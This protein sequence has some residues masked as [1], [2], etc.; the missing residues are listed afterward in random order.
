M[1]LDGKPFDDVTYEDILALI[2]DVSENRRLDYKQA[3]PNDSEKSV[4]DFLADVCALANS[5]G[6]Y[7]VFGV[8]EE[9]D[10]DNK[11]NGI[12][13][14]VCGVG[15]INED[16]T[17]LKWQTRISQAIEPTLIQH[18]IRFIHGFED[19]GS[20]MVVY[21]QKS[22]F[23]PHRVNYQG[24]KEFY[25]RHDS[26]NLPMDMPQ[27][28]HAFVEGKEVPQRIDEFRRQRVMQI[29]AGE[30]PI[31]LLDEW[32]VFVGHLL[33]L[34]HFASDAAVDVTTLGR[35]S[36]VNIMSR[37]VGGGRLNADG[38]LFT[39]GV[40]EDYS[41]GYLQVHRSGAIEFVATHHDI[42]SKTQRGTLGLASQWQ[43]KGFIASVASS[44]DI[45]RG[46]GVQP[47][48]YI[49]LSVL[50][51]K[52]V[53]MI[54]PQRYFDEGDLIDKDHL[55]V[56]VVTSETLDE[57]VDRL[58]RPAFDAVWQASGLATSPYYNEDGDWT[59]Q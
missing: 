55:I 7:L 28:R 54:R 58:L 16:A 48:V 57:P 2:P 12:P 31:P 32:T 37:S 40:S 49:G 39:H 20:V 25:L 44:L 38:F 26:G 42:P 15:D 19:G 51:V 33:P 27:I 3:L 35:H 23:T 43:E 46:L 56:P 22:L 45:L 14:A 59:G 13:K 8:E 4:K 1:I 30:T 18:R 29:L 10:E 34:S 41:R 21:I 11:P 6:G 9:R 47:P 24:K 53:V 52:G 36:T 5:A 50:R 17:V